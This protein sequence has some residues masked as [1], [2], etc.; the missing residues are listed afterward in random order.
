MMDTVKKVSVFWLSRAQEN[1][2][3]DVFLTF[4]MVFFK[5]TIGL[6]NRRCNGHCCLEPSCDVYAGRSDSKKGHLTVGEEQKFTLV[7]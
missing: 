1:A 5:G 2:F 7:C 3:P 4:A 6:W